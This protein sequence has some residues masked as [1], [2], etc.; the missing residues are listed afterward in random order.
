MDRVSLFAPTLDDQIACVEREIAL[1]RRAYPRFVFN[2]RMTREKADRE[3]ELMEH[4]LQT[5]QGLKRE[6]S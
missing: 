4:V 6:P 5:L 1:R 2:H 3:I